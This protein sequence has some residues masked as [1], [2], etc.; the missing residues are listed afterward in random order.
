MIRLKLSD[1]APVLTDITEEEKAFLLKKSEDFDEARKAQ[2]LKLESGQITSEEA[3]KLSFCNATE[4][5]QLANIFCKLATSNK[6]ASNQKELLQEASYFIIQK[7]PQDS[8]NPVSVTT[9]FEIWF[10]FAKACIR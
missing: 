10:G 8:L 2:D 7:H 9:F 5:R 4:L 1:V 3:K 6:L